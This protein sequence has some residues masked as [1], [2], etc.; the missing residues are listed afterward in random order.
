MSKERL[1]S[2]YILNKTLEDNC[3]WLS[4]TEGS[5]I[6]G[7][8]E[9]F[10]AQEVEAAIAETKNK[11]IG[12]DAFCDRLDNIFEMGN[13]T[14]A[15]IIDAYNKSVAERIPTE[16][17]KKR[18]AIKYLRSLHISKEYKYEKDNW[19]RTDFMAGINAACN[20]MTG[21]DK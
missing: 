12:V 4:T 20:Y 18:M 16:E 19:F 13:P 5:S 11:A 10:A 1:T 6:I 15:Q 8:M 17:E 7:A 21:G 9:A 14:K 2:T 3:F